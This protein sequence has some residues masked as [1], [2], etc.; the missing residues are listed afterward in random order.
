VRV[1]QIRGAS[2]DGQRP[3]GSRRL[4]RHVLSARERNLRRLESNE[5]E[6]RRMHLLNDAFQVNQT[7]KVSVSD[8]VTL[9]MRVNLLTAPA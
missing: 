7:Y 9:E 8:H 5:R 2:P 4:R 6:R 3:A 1:G